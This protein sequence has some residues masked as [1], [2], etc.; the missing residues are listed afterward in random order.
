MDIPKID[1]LK[2][3]NKNWHIVLSWWSIIEP[4]TVSRIYLSDIQ[5]KKSR[6]ISSS[7]PVVP[8]LPLIISYLS[9]LPVGPTD[10]SICTVPFASLYLPPRVPTVRA[11]WKTVN[12]RRDQADSHKTCSFNYY[13]PGTNQANVRGTICQI[14]YN[15]YS[16]SLPPPSF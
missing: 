14:N 2:I 5:L 3:E 16:P 4:K 7:H 1:I 8:Y 15:G 10:A 6:K 13:N 11:K 12:I 9:P